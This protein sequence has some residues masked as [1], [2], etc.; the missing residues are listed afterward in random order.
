M[1]KRTRIFPATSLFFAA[2]QL[3]MNMANAADLTWNNGASTGF[4]N[5]TDANWTGSTWSNAVPDNA[6]FTTV[7]GTVTLATGVTA[8]TVS[9]GSSTA[10][11]ANLTL[12]GGSL[13]ATSL[14]AQGN[15]SNSG[16]YG[17]NPTLTINSTV[18]LS[19]SLLIG[20][21]NVTISGGTLTTDRITT[22]PASADWANL[23]I[24]GGTVT[25]TNGVDG[26]YGTTGANGT[27]A[28]FNINLNGGVLATNYVKVANREAGSNNNAWL[29]FNGGTLRA[30]ADNTNFIQTYG[31]GS[32]VYISSGG[33]TIDTNGFSVTVDR[34]LV[35]TSG[36]TGT[37]TKTGTG[38]LTLSGANT[39][40]GTTT[41]SAGRLALQNTY[42]SGTHSIS[43]GAFLE[44]NVA[45]GS[46]DFRATTFNGLGTLVKTGAGTAT[47]G[48]A[49]GTFALGSGSLIDIQGGTFTG[50]SNANEIWTN[51][52]S[53][54]NVASGAT[55]ST[56][57]ANV[58]VNKI[59]GSGTIGTGFNG[60]NYANLTI[61]VDN[62][63]STFSGVIQNTDNNAS[64]V[65]NLVK[66][67]SG[68]IALAGT[69][70]YTG[71]TTVTAGTLSISGSV[72][73][74]SGFVVSGTLD[75]AATNI[76]TGGHRNP[77]NG[78]ITI[79]AGGTVINSNNSVNRI[80]NINLNGG[81][82]TATFNE[83]NYG[84]Y[85]IGQANSVD[86][87]VTVAGSTASTIN[88]TNNGNIRMWS[89]VNFNVSDVTGNANTDLLVSAALGN[90]TADQGSAAA[91]LTKQGAGTMVL[92][93]ANNYTGTTTIS[94]GTLQIGAG[95][96]T[97]SL[98]SPSVTSG[99]LSFGS[100]GA[101]VNNSAL[102]YNI[103]G[104]SL[105]VNRTISGSGTV[106]ATGNQAVNFAS[107]TTINTTGSQTYSATATSGRFNGFTIADNGTVTLT[108][109]GGNISMTGMLGTAN[110]N[111]G[112]LNVD[113]STGNGNVTLNTPSGISSVNF[114]MASLTV[115]AGT[116]TIS[117]GT[118]NSLN[119]GTITTISLTG[120]SVNST[121]NLTSFTNLNVT[122][123]G[124]SSFSG[125][126]TASGGA[127]TKSG[128]GT[129]TLSG[130]NTYTGA[131]TIANGTLSASNIVVNAGSSHLGNATSAVT[132]G[133][134]STQGVLSYTGNS[135]TFT[136]GFTIG[137]A[138]GGR[139]NV[140]TDGQTLQVDTGAV[141]GS[142]LF[143]VGGAGNTTINANLT[144]TGGL[145][146]EDAGTLTLA[147]NGNTFAGLTT[148]NNGSLALTSGSGLTSGN[149]L[150]L[151]ASG[152]A[153]FANAGQTL[154]AV[155]NANTT[156][157]ALN[158]SAATGTVTLA[159]LSGAGNTRFGSNGTVTGGVSTGTVN[160]V[161][162]L[163]ASISGG[164]VG[165]GSLS[166]TTMSGGTTTVSGTA[167]I[168]TMS[169]GTANL[170]G[171][172]SAITSLNGGTVNLGALTVLSVSNGTTSG[173]IT[174][175]GGGLTKTSA[176]TL[177]LSSGG[178]YNY[179]GA[180]NVNE[181]TLVVNGNISTS[182][183]T[184]AS[185]ATIGGSGTVGA[186]TINA[187]GTVAPGNSPGILNTGNY[188][189]AGTLVAEI[190]GLVAGSQYDQINVA[191]SVTL[192]GLLSLNTS[193]AG[194]GYA[195]NSMIFLILNDASDAVTGTFTGLAQG[196]TAA[197]FG[198]FD[199]VI[200]YTANSTDT[201][202]T[203]GNDVA[204]MAIPEPSA[205]LLGGLGVLGL[206][207]RRRK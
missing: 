74:S 168:G 160:A 106:N 114:G 120:G 72:R 40:S 63:S 32:N 10:N 133:A 143:T 153:S 11:F 202:F 24:S 8:G 57:E 194:N 12:S 174:G 86:P 104:G 167:T 101:I 52:L 94:A 206:L 33:A 183:V 93:A 129:L 15:G 156:T 165:A 164:T 38:T 68:T 170:N 135:A 3:T 17:S 187:G 115:T 69:N 7:G 176:G 138:G 189:Q 100:T 79:N 178:T 158:F 188:N 200:S 14:V 80:G 116:G 30:L 127:L 124:A 201:T 27:G 105:H 13:T 191:G 154:G 185:G 51:N 186:L 28:T 197:T 179:T 4:W 5:T 161:G 90:Q 67:G 65:G 44:L 190:T 142:G 177:T 137:G 132:L 131:T 193:N 203:G 95:G 111:T 159:S 195:L 122:N 192:S 55:F 31:G 70:T 19:G 54:L 56:V 71:T 75:V 147:G 102:V 66:V 29:T 73:S 119:W 139:L 149:D 98:Y 92:S 134:A 196:A 9:A 204:L 155:S 82:L 46:R 16:A 130:T 199:W 59:T 136:R 123:S 112:N 61:G 2:I 169:S 152:S 108:S 148:V 157:N 34:T 60:A 166:S 109:T 125:N 25:A 49:A 84:S 91:S 36:Q 99:N 83:A 87:T 76:F 145:T 198:G 103:V 180:T 23:T 110:G 181:G 85:F 81:T 22:N 43:S 175:A 173:S 53:D 35:N 182:N 21:S 6:I 184:V 37:L 113:T 117:L 88:A 62:G 121:A 89:N 42:S 48:S 78:T 58:R 126:L 151:G 172:M 1:K 207:R 64:Y 150:T 171:A 97:G 20:R 41:V 107:G 205:A 47:W 146:K 39:Y 144:H 162:L 96:S 141:T 118:H 77:M 45:S 18:N 26:T 140:T 163:T 128:A 50:G